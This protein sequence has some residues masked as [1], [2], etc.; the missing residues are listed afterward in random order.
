MTWGTPVEA[1]ERAD[2]FA[3]PRHP[4]PQ[5]LLSAAPI[6]AP[7]VQRHRQRIVLSGEVPSPVNPP[8]GCR[9]HTRCPVAESRCRTEEPELRPVGDDGALVACHL[10]ADNGAGP[11][12]VE[13][14]G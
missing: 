12:L 9:F 5:A 13:A 11:R 7:P 14:L 3:P 6:P 2:F 8:A 1:A 10:V 4:Y